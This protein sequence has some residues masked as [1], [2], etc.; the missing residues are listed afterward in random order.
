MSTYL[1]KLL[2]SFMLTNTVLFDFTKDANINNWVIV[3]DEVMGGV[4]HGHFSL[5]SE[6]YG[7]FEGSVS[8]ENNGGFSSVRYQC[9]STNNINAN[10]SILVR[11][12]GDGK[13]Y[14]LRIKHKSNNYYSYITFF[15]TSG[16]WETI[17]IPLKNF[18]PSFRGQTLNLPNFDH[19]S[20]E[21]IAFLIGNKKAETF[22]LLID[23][24]EVN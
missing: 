13:I 15:A 16:E 7:I 6:G 2:L 12:K 23:K 22:K 19:E 4:S 3:D 17:N 10:Q 14:Q 8:L 1:I 24:I 5:S 21:E 9:S 18:Y 11:L 20:I